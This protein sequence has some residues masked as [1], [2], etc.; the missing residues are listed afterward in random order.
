MLSNVP[1]LQDETTYSLLGS[2]EQID[3]KCYLMVSFLQDDIKREMSPY[4]FIRTK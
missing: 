3:R 1:H 2:S 4:G